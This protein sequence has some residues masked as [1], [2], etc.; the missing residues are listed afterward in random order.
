M[1]WI[2][3]LLRTLNFRGSGHKVKTITE[4]LNL[5]DVAVCVNKDTVIPANSQVVISAK[6]NATCLEHQVALFE[7][8]S[9]KAMK[10]GLIVSS[11][12]VN[13][14]GKDAS[15]PVS[16]SNVTM[17]NITLHKNTSVSKLFEVDT[18]K[19]L[20]NNDSSESKSDPKARNIRKHTSC[21]ISDSRDWRGIPVPAIDTW[22]ES[23]Q[24]LYH[25][26]SVSLPA[27]EGKQLAKLIEFHRGAFASSPTDLGQTSVVTHS[28]DTGDAKP[29]KQQPRRTP[30][31]FEGEEEKI[32]QDQLQAGI[33]QESTS[34]WSSPLVYVR[35]KDGS[36]RPCVDFRRLNE[37]TQKM[38]YPLPLTSSCLDSLNG[39]RYMSSLDL[40]SGYW[41]IKVDE[42]DRPKTAFT[43]KHGL[44]KYLVMPFGLTNAPGTFQRCME[45]IFRGLQWKSL[46]IF[47]DDI[48]LFND[49]FE[50]HLGNLNE[51][52]ERLTKAGLKLKPSKCNLIR[53]E[54][55][56][57]GHVVSEAGITVDPEK[58][59]A[60]V[61]WPVPKNVHDIRVF[62]GFCS[63]YRRFVRGF[64]SIV[65]PL[66]H[67]LEAEVKFE[68]TE[69]CMD[70]FK[71]L[72][73]ILTSQAVMAY[74][75]DSG[76]LILD[77]DASGTGVGATL[78]LMQFCEKTGREEERPIAHASKSMN[79]AQRQY[80]VTRKELL[81]VVY[82]VQYF[83]HYLLGRDFVIR[84]DHSALR[85]VMSF[86]DPRDQI[87]RWLEVLSQYR[88]KIVHQDG[89]KHRNADSLSRVPCDPTE[90][91]CYDGQTLLSDLPCGGYNVC[92]KR[93]EHVSKT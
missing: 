13:P 9:R 7:P 68:W 44:Y 82:F 80:C 23:L 64:S 21:N 14:S 58:I 79:K 15:I 32:I 84:T 1:G 70:A 59:R 41:Q 29:I 5:E 20:L 2:F 93:H 62:I 66:T 11:C 86:K 60:V 56:F 25:R 77:T 19:V 26:S 6:I 71:K 35:K 65:G 12:L 73:E 46:V 3:F 34:P 24:D 42:K 83:R 85:W 63:Y 48:I 28:I 53:K 89:K 45:I 36:T 8:I 17:E 49:T 69:E 39:A 91:S 57:L 87:A 16:V 10:R 81:A 47:L 92:I 61:D 72:K 30:R 74:P 33:I 78:S 22:P 40:Q 18:V 27:H 43:S 88:F 37:V 31:A 76:L 67:L 4:G 52:L 75:K 38:A 54:V 50:Q 51:V 90:C 55:L